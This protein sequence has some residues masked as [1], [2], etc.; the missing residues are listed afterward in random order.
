MEWETTANHPFPLIQV[1]KLKKI[2]GITNNQFVYARAFSCTVGVFNIWIIAH[3]IPPAITTM[4]LP[5]A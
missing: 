3:M 5:V 4:W 2:E 1:L